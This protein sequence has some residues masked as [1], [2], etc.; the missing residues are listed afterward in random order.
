MKNPLPSKT[1]T[2]QTLSEFKRSLLP[3]SQATAEYRQVVR[4]LGFDL[5]NSERTGH[6]GGFYS[7]TTL[8]TDPVHSDRRFRY[9]AVIDSKKLGVT[10]VFE[11]GGAP[12]IY[13][14][15]L[16]ADP[17]PE[18][19]RQWH[20][21]A[22]NHGL[23]RMLWI[24]TPSYIQ[25]LNSFK[26]PVEV[27]REETH[28]AELIR[29]ATDDLERL[30]EF[31]LDRVSL[32][33]GQFWSTARGARI[34]KSERIDAKLAE[35]LS[36]A[37]EML[38]K[39]GCGQLASHRLM[40]RTMFTAYLEAR[41]VLP[42]EL[43][44]DLDAQEFCDVLRST[45]DTQTFFERMRDT[46]NGDLFPPPPK[47]KTDEDTYTFAVEH[48]D[49][50]RRI[51]TREDLNTG[52]QAFDFWRYD[53]EI[54]PI[55]L[56][57][58]IYERFIYADDRELAK[59]RGTHYTPVN[60][61]DLVFSQ[62]FDDGLFESALPGKPKV[63]DLACGSGVFLVEAFRRLV[64]RRVSEGEKLTR[65]LVRDVL[66]HQLFGVDLEET[67]IEIAAFSLC[68]TAFELDPSPTS[69][70]QL[71]FR[72]SL[73]GRNLFVSDAFDDNTLGKQEEF[74]ERQFSLVVGNPPWNKPLGGRSTRTQSLRSHIEYCQSKDPPIELPYRSPIDQAF[75]WRGRDFAKRGA[76][77]GLIIDAKNFFSQVKQSLRAQR[78]LYEAFATREMINLSSLHNKGLFPSAEQPAMIYVA[79][80]AEPEA[81]NSVLFL[82]A[83][84]SESFRQH[85]MIN[86]NV[87]N[88]SRLPKRKLLT[89]D[90]LLKIASFGSA[91]DL[92]IVSRL[93]RDYGSLGDYIEK[94]GM[95]LRQG[96]IKGTGSRE[97]PVAV[98]QMPMLE[99]E[100]LQRWRQETK[101]LP[102]MSYQRVQWPRSEEIYKADI[103]LLKQSLQD[104]RL[105]ATVCTYDV[106]Y[107]VSYYG[108]PLDGQPRW[109][110]ELI[111]AF[112]NSSLA[113]YCFFLT[114]TRF[115]IDKQ[116]V[117]PNDLLR[118][119]FRIP[120]KRSDC[121]TLLREF[122]HRASSGDRDGFE[123]LDE[124]VFDYFDI[125]IWDREYI[126]SVIRYDLEFARRGSKS[127]A[128]QSASDEVL[129]E[130][131]A[132]VLR[133]I[134]ANLVDSEIICNIEILTGMK[135][136]RAIVVR[137]GERI[138]KDI[139]YI[140]ATHFA[141]GDR[142]AELLYAPISANFQSRRSLMFFDGE[143]C[144]I[145]KHDQRRF[146]SP[147]RAQDDADSIFAKL[148]EPVS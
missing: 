10:D 90:C 47:S 69:V 114:S 107:S 116:I 95:K 44:D 45:K 12:C 61:V 36:A 121:E 13:F 17:S 93:Q 9:A 25:I 113:M 142:L 8:A 40:L 143:R 111:S 110:G 30:R 146:W 117:M 15:S 131:A 109:T 92:A 41:G 38:V 85:G 57:S 70:R 5:G 6:L 128:V 89:C 104:E 26:P 33:S 42:K 48:L 76:R 140:T 52:Q 100:P 120:S 102:G 105:I 101:N 3:A 43:F 62:V 108:I 82:S 77:F 98:Q 63:L 35:D 58:S 106:A 24:V 132:S 135:D 7:A 1:S 21:T 81:S 53:F 122:D 27:V 20:R 124:A 49:I 66:E 123:S 65:T 71:K 80:N 130:Y 56:I 46:F 19:V 147:A 4:E 18:E 148:M 134:R 59:K 50:A 125:D 88:S 75:I 39:Q 97:V 86:L 54:I 37:G 11:L 139:A 94:L 84:R 16:N 78:G 72:R 22:W 127:E 96:F 83:E 141:P 79:E 137:F 118:L 23:G 119:P 138:E 126:S 51:V 29:V 129:K 34:K 136:I 2:T 144:V 60:L 103:C 115:G 32:E 68:L 55:E 91:R 87:E 112:I 99:N 14:K 31:E 28:P 133:A 145:V 67:A 64:A 73:K 74:K